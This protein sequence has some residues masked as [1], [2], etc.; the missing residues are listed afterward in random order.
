MGR[1]CGFCVASSSS[2]SFSLASAWALVVGLG[3]GSSWRTVGRSA[4]DRSVLASV[5]VGK[6]PGG[7]GPDVE[8]GHQHLAPKSAVDAFWEFNLRWTRLESKR[9][10]F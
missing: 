6:A 3:S 9:L 4:L 7:A 2:V 10:R 5:R 1:L 8:A